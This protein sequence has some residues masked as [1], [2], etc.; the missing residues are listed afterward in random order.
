[1]KRSEVR[2]ARGGAS[3]DTVLRIMTM[4]QPRTWSK[5][6]H[7]NFGPYVIQELFT[8]DGYLPLWL[9]LLTVRVRVRVT[10]LHSLPS[11]PS[12]HFHSLPFSSSTCTLT[13]MLGLLMLI[14]HSIF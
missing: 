5:F 6:R 14:A 2:N 4:P 8:P 7:V 11:P 1:M 13:L 3:N 12:W 10:L 9:G